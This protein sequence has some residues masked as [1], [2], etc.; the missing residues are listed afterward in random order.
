MARNN[1][2]LFWPVLVAVTAADAVTKAMA[3]RFLPLPLLPHE[4]LGN[5]VRLTLVYN[6]GAAF[7]IS[8]GPYSRWIFMALIV[9][10]L[11]ILSRLYATTRPGNVP[12]TL[13]LALV[14]GGAVG[15]LVDRLRSGMGVVDFIDVGLR[16]ARWPTFNVADMA[17]TVGAVLL[18]IVLWAEDRRA[19]AA[20][21]PSPSPAIGE[22][23]AGEPS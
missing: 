23:P 11:A 9:A 19:A 2:V 10:A 4:V 3:Q 13:A 1:A 8:F 14:C 16:N 18:A 7:G 6:P 21:A 17:V 20:A 12:R 5:A 15:N 22:H